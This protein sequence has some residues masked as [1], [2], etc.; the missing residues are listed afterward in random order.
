[1]GVLGRRLLKVGAFVA[2]N[3]KARGLINYLRTNFIAD[4]SLMELEVY[5]ACPDVL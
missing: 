3:Q 4:F 5:P 2:V 1:M